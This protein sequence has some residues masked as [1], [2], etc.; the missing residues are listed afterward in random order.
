MGVAA[1]LKLRPLMLTIVTQ[2]LSL[3]A[4][5]LVPAHLFVTTLSW[6][7]GTLGRQDAS[8]CRFKRSGLCRGTSTQQLK[9]GHSFPRFEDSN[10]KFQDVR[11]GQD[12][13]GLS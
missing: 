2:F 7:A 9:D 11:I 4:S 5:G 10:G 6:V 12:R 1:I 8:F 13:F 3:F